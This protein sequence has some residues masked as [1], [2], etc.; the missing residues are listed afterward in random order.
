MHKEINNASKRNLLFIFKPP[1]C[2]S[3]TEA[4]KTKIDELFILDDPMCLWKA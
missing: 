2:F 4:L 1:K 3:V